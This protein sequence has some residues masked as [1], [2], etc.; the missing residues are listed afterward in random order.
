MSKIC[1]LWLFSIHVQTGCTVI[2][3]LF[4]LHKAFDPCYGVNNL[5]C[6]GYFTKRPS[7][8]LPKLYSV[9]LNVQKAYD[10]SWCMVNTTIET[11]IQFG[12]LRFVIH[13]FW[14]LYEYIPILK[15]VK[16]ATLRRDFARQNDK[17]KVQKRILRM[18][19]RSVCRIYY[20]CYFGSGFCST[21]EL[22]WRVWRWKQYAQVSKPFS[23][24]ILKAGLFT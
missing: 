7:I 9:S 15:C 18:Y 10:I 5:E 13:I 16:F 2:S 22:L 17:Y 12:I 4:V 19:V 23:R 6:P 24:S 21:A 14:Q 11:N 3:A 20:G 1:R 8:L